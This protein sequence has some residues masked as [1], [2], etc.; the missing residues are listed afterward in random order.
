MSR[1]KTSN[2][3][4][5]FAI[6]LFAVSLCGVLILTGQQ[7]ALTAGPFTAAQANAGRGAYATSCAACHGANLQG[8]NDAVQ[9]AGLQFMG[10]WGPRTAGDL[11]AFISAAM[12]PGQGNSLSAE[13]YINIT[14]FILQQNGATPSNTALT[15]N[16]TVPIRAIANGRAPQGGGQGGGKQQAKQAAQG[17]QGKQADTGPRGITVAGEV[18]N[19]TPVTDAMLRNPDPNEWLIL[20]HDYKATNY[21]TLN[22]INANNVQNLHLVWSW[23]MNDGTNQAAPL[24]HSGVMFVNNANNFVQAIDARTGELI[25]EN[26]LG[27]S[28][29][30]QRGLALYDDKVYV[31]TGEARIYALDARTG[32]NIWDSLI[33]DRSTG[34][35]STSSGPIAIKGKLVQGLG[36]CSRYQNEKCFI[37]AWDAQ[38]GKEAWRFY[39]IAKEGEPGGDTWGKLPNLFRAGGE[40]WITGSYDPDLNLT[41][42]GV[43]QSKPWMR[44]SRGSGNGETQ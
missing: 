8:Q 25:W 27:G 30:S 40:T 19:Y 2:L 5:R 15:Q 1:I 39:T 41:Y 24:V 20:R 22:Q 3:K 42:W 26:R 34:A 33:G 36:G 12:P 14:A 37:S 16:S 9:L 29:N 38:T 21:S 32:K 13:T 10:D 11:A 17:K 28:G 31:T 7:P 44:P 43:A 35:Y 23:A 4:T 18:K 6:A